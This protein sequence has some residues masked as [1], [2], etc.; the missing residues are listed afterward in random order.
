MTEK[1]QRPASSASYK[2]KRPC[3]R[4]GNFVHRAIR[5]V[6]RRPR[7]VL[8]KLCDDRQEE[9]S[10]ANRVMRPHERHTAPSELLLVC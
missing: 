1:S 7:S 3:R 5:V 8:L 4:P 9:V 6:P 10:L 2:Y